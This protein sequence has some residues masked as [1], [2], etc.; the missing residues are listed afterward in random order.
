MRKLPDRR[1]L[2]FPDKPFSAYCTICWHAEYSCWVDRTW[3]GGKC[4]FGADKIEQCAQAMDTD[5]VVGE[6]KKYLSEHRTP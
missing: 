1:A 5:R 4:P 2:A 3:H 6:I